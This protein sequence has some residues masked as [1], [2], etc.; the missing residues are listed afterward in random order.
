MRY[1]IQTER[2]DL[3]DVNIVITML[4]RINRDIEY[5]RLNYAFHEACKIHEVLN[6][7]VVIDPDGDA[8]Y[9]SNDKPLNNFSETTSDLEGIIAS[10]EGKRFLI[11]KGEFIRGFKSPDGI[12]FMMHHLG[13]DGRSLLY[14]IETFF[15]FLNGEKVE[16]IPFKN[17]LLADLPSGS[18][19]PFYYDRLVNH[20]NKKWIRSGR[21]FDYSDMDKAYADFWKDHKTKTT[22]RTYDKNEL[23]K[24]L[25]SARKCKVSLTSYLITD[26][27]KDMNFKPEVGIAVD[28]RTDKIHF[29]GNQVTGI[30]LKYRYNNNISFD[31]NARNVQRLL[32]GRLS[33]KKK[34]YF[35]LQFMGKLNPSLR[36]ALNLNR[37]GYYKDKFTDSVASYLGYGNKI[38]DLSVTNLMRAD[39]P[40]EYG[41]YKIDEIIFVPPVVAY[42]Q[43]VIGII[44]TGDKM[45]VTTHVYEE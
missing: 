18:S 23:D 21:A 43:N 7:K 28:A 15:M 37:A 24:L 32:K 12:V 9:T 10:E 11:E 41:P 44:T 33:D 40:L 29:M 31:D 4:V 30:S 19:L 22:I 42:A 17:L 36:D 35:A 14:F 2:V 16:K 27:I 6:L 8:Y 5:D 13:G 45:N 39:I 20:W 38:R 34:R 26:H 3:F 25:E 1:E